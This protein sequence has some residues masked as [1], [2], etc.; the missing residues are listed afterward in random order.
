MLQM[1]MASGTQGH[2]A[3]KRGPERTNSMAGRRFTL[4][5][6]LAD[7][8]LAL[9]SNG[10][11]GTRIKQRKKKSEKCPFRLGTLAAEGP[12]DRRVRYGDAS[13][14]RG[15]GAVPPAPYNAGTDAPW[16]SFEIKAVRPRPECFPLDPF[17]TVTIT[18]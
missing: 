8:A 5:Q 2:G 11:A 14:G 12:L 3:P 9:R 16:K 1:L 13:G 6:D 10:A 4:C 17:T 15:P 7:V 18:D